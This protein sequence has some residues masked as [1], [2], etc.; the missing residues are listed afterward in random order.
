MSTTHQA[1]FGDAEYSFRLTPK[2]ITELEKNTGMGFGLLCNRV[3]ARQFAMS[4]LSEVIR[5]ALCGG[6][7]APQRAAELVATYV[8]DRPISEVY[9]LAEAILE[10]RYFG[11]PHHG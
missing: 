2:L 3:F 6:G 4:D 9:P 1:F 10:A 7:M 8:A 5:L 11:V